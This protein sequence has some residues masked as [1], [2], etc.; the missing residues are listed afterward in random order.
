MMSMDYIVQTLK[1]LQT[2]KYFLDT[3]S[4]NLKF[5]KLNRTI[6][7]M[8]MGGISGRNIKSYIISTREILNH[9]K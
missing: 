1:L 7:R 2:L 9:S 5:Y 4:K 6:V 3:F 8:R